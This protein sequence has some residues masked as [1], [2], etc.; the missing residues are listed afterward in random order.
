MIQIVLRICLVSLIMQTVSG[1]TAP[2][3]QPI[4]ANQSWSSVD[5]VYHRNFSYT[6]DNNNHHI[7]GCHLVSWKKKN[8]D[9]RSFDVLRCTEHIKLL[10]PTAIASTWQ[11]EQKQLGYINLYAKKIMAGHASPGMQ[12]HITLIQPVKLDPVNFTR[13]GN[14]HPVTALF[15]RHARNVRTYKFKNMKTGT[16]STVNATANHPFYVKNKRKFV[17]VS[18]ISTSDTLLT[19][20]G[21]P[22]RLICR[23]GNK[24]H[25]GTLYKKGQIT[26]VYNMETYPNHT[27]FVGE[28][29]P[30]LVHNCSVIATET[31]ADQNATGTINSGKSEDTLNDREKQKMQVRLVE[32]PPLEN[33]T[34]DHCLSLSDVKKMD[35]HRT[36]ELLSP[37]TGN[38]VVAI[39]DTYGNQVETKYI[40]K[41][42]QQENGGF[43]ISNITDATRAQ[44]INRQIEYYSLE[45]ERMQRKEYKINTDSESEHR[46]M[47]KRRRN[48]VRELRKKINEN[49]NKLRILGYD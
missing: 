17:P 47:K 12:A 25:C 21:Q 35:R 34:G 10:I 4:T 30:V 28:S 29:S 43:I 33:R 19:E 39:Q 18:S 23:K 27:Y 44:R 1:M 46:L 20:T 2:H 15:I 31:A 6:G 3:G 8:R 49:V 41:I 32:E 24:K 11:E 37:F 40:Q 7:A 22:V 13:A 9:K 38:K 26:T 42:I 5:L 36:K 48:R 45:I 14:K 16:V